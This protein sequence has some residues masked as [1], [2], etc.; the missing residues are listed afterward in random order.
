MGDRFILVVIST[1]I[2]ICIV[3]LDAVA[4][5]VAWSFVVDRKF[6]PEQQSVA[7]HAVDAKREKVG[8][9][10]IQLPDSG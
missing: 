8:H 4:R 3:E 7:R 10:P 5:E 6:G 2:V 9:E 1:C